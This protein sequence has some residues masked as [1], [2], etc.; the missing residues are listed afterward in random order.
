MIEG[1]QLGPSVDPWA[2]ILI[3]FSFHLGAG[4]CQSQVEVAS[5]PN[6]ENSQT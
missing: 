6:V 4:P 1:A 5:Q 3:R 2:G